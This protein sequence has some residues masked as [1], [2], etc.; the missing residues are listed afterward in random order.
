MSQS[1]LV[2]VDL[3]ALMYRSCLSPGRRL[4]SPSGEPTRGVQRILQTLLP[5]LDQL[6][7][8]YLVLCDDGHRRD[9]W[10][11]A[12]YPPYKA[13]RDDLDPDPDLFPQIKRIRSLLAGMGLPRVL[14]PDQEADDV[15]ATIAHICSG[16]ECRVTIVGGDKDLHQLV[17]EDV[18]IYDVMKEVRINCEYVRTKWGVQ[19]PRQVIDIQALMG[20]GVDGIPGAPGIGEKYA[21]E[22]IGEYGTVWDVLCNWSRLKPGVQKKLSTWDFEMMLKL[23][24]LQQDCTIDL[25][26]D[27]MAYDKYD[28]AAVR[29]DLLTLGFTQWV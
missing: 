20:D 23:V 8:D 11:R 17:T 21:K 5:L 6:R 29:N 4:T 10:R 7:P 26:P 13:K 2:L 1:H 14:I 19:D 28:L 9:L 27:Q 16:P 3:P 22:L 12:I 24:T 25:T 18:E 15:I